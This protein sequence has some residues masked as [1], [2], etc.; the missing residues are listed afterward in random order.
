M[1]AD[2]VGN[3]YIQFIRELSSKCANN[4]IVLSVDNYVPRDYT[5]FYNRAE[6]ALFADY[7]V[8]MAYDEH[9]AGSRKLV[10]LLRLVSL[11]DGVEN[12][13]KE[14]PANQV[15]LSMPFYTRVW[16][17]TPVESDS[18]ATD[19]TDTTVD[20]ELSSY[21]TNMTEVQKLIGAN[22]V[23][24]VWLDDIGQV[25]RISKW[26]CQLQDLD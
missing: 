7:V 15:I 3:S 1:N 5:A 20:Y 4:G 6:Q 17:E 2:A 12:T 9:Y 21:A 26:W 14:V 25:C 23:Q 18:T 10:P 11:T 13:L 16:S 24:P 8:I 22:G 19:E